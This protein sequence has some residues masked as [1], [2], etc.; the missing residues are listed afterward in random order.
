MTTNFSLK[1]KCAIV[2]GGSRGIGKA[3]TKALAEAGI[4][5]RG[6]S[7]AAIGKRFV[8]HLALDTAEDAAKWCTWMRGTLSDAAVT[9]RA[10]GVLAL[11]AVAGPFL[12][13]RLFRWE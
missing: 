7:A 5:L 10:W 9:G 13:S 1:G 11:W 2:T 12:A 6:L 3:I 8:A 4:N